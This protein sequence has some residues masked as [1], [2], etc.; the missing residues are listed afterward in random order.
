M[1]EI[2][3]NKWAIG[4]VV[5]NKAWNDHLFTLKIEAET[6][7]F[8]AGQFTRLAL[9]V[10]DEHVARPYSLVNTDNQSPVEVY[11]NEVADGPLSPRLAAL[12]PGDKIDVSKKPVG[13]FTL[14]EVPQGKHL[15]LLATGSGLGPYI[16]ILDTRKPWDEYEKI[17]LVHGIG[18][19]IDLGYAEHLQSLADNHAEQFTYIQS[20]TR[21]KVDSALHARIP[22]ALESGQLESITGLDV[23]SENTRVMICG[24]IDMIRDTTAALEDR[25]L[26]KH[27]RSDPG[28][29]ITEKYW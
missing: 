1:K 21:E 25:G 6:N 27:K 9:T 10:D 12:K 20:V 28:Q 15:W 29:I 11:F 2:D 24:N 26:K 17:I 22:D 3:R 4:T 23:N 19:Q 16:S 7:A 14:E 18:H 8:V 5:E 13:F